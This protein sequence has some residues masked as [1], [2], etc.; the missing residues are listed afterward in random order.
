MIDGCV[1]EIQVKVSEIASKEGQLVDDAIFGHIQRIANEEGIKIDV[2]LNRD[3]IIKALQNR[4]ENT[5]KHGKWVKY[6]LFDLPRCSICDE[7]GFGLHAFDFRE[8]KYC[9]HCGAKMDK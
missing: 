7:P 2:K 4:Q 5:V 6:D 1:H 9:P 3:F 8:T